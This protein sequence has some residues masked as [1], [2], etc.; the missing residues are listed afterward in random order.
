[1]EHPKPGPDS[2]AHSMLDV[3]D[4]T[5]LSH[6]ERIT[7]TRKGI[8]GLPMDLV[9]VAC[10]VL[11]AERAGDPGDPQGKKRLYRQSEFHEEL[12]EM[13]FADDQRL[14]GTLD[15][16]IEQGYVKID[17]HG[18]IT[19]GKPAISM[20]RLLDHAFPGMPG[21]NLVAY[22]VQTLDE[23]E[24]GRKGAKDAIMQLDQMLRRHGAARF[25]RPS[26]GTPPDTGL[27][28]KKSET[29]ALKKPSR[30]KRPARLRIPDEM[31]FPASEVPAPPVEL[32]PE[33]QMPEEAGA[34]DTSQIHELS[35]IHEETGGE[36]L[37][38]DFVTSA[39]DIPA[40]EEKT[41]DNTFTPYG[42]T[43]PVDEESPPGTSLEQP[44]DVEP[45]LETPLTSHDEGEATFPGP[46]DLV[47]ERVAAFEKE[48]AMQCPVCRKSSIEVRETAKGRTYY[49]CADE[50]CMFIS[51]GKPHHVPCPL[52]GN[53]FLVEASSG[54]GSIILK[55][56]RATCRYRQEPS[57]SHAAKDYKE[58]DSKPATPATEGK[59]R[60]RVV[61]RKVMR[62]KR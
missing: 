28:A 3:L 55:C 46:E 36:G 14:Q 21:M 29:P 33:T 50:Q 54:E 35:G 40:N 31:A 13:G 4:R 12:T 30:P 53:P 18:G 10:I 2:F 58:S 16:M 5:L 17:P 52:C 47:D 19:P 43:E 11:M 24:S 32:P 25:S 49:K 27:P 22:F 34:G 48:L 57:V 6:L 42:K 59:P 26:K 56:P 38:P 7:G 9:T 20:A 1:M 41:D 45:D 8:H 60:R 44:R 15:S 37:V 62:R 51:W 23:V 39:P 61:R